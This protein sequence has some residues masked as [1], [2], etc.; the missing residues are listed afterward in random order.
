M[1]Y[2]AASNVLLAVNEKK[3]IAV[4]LYRPLRN[5]IASTFSERDAQDAEDDLQTVRKLR[6]D[7]EAGFS[8]SLELRRDL[9][10]SYLRALASI[11]PRFPISPDR[12]HV[13]SLTFTWFDAFR[14]N[15]KAALP[16][17]HLEKA[18]V[19]FNLGAVYS[20]IAVAADRTSASGLKQACNA[21]QSAAGA[22]SFLKD[23]VAAKAVAA[24]GTID[25]SVECTVMLEKLMLAQ[26]QECFFQKV[27]GDAKP[28]G[29]CSKVARQVGIYY[30]EAYAALNASLLNQHFDRT[31]MSH[32]QLKAAQ[33]YS[34][35]CYQYSLE[36]H[37]KEE[38]AEEIARLKIGISALTDAKKSAKGVA[39]PSLDAVKKLDTNMNNNLERAVKE[40]DRVYLMRIPAASSLSALPT[41]SLVKPTSL[42]EVLDASEEKF[43]SKLVPDSHTKAFSKYTDMAD[44]I[45]RIQL[46]KLQQGS[47]ITRVKLKELD[48]P[49]SILSLEGNIG[50]PFDLKEDVEVVQI[51]GGPSGLET[52]IQQLK[53]LRR[54]NQEL[55]A[56]SEE[57]LQKEADTDAQFRSQFGTRWTRPESNTLTKNIQ[58]KLHRFTVNLKQAADTDARVEREVRD[59]VEFLAILDH[60][61]IESTLPS[62]ARPIIS[63]DGNEDSIVG[64]LK[65]SLRQLENLGAQRAGLEDM[66]KE[67]KMK[68]NI[69]P[70]LMASTVSQED[71]F[72]KEISKYDQICEEISQNINAQEQLLLQIQS[73][74]DQFAA[75]FNLE[76]YKVLVV[77]AD[78][79]MGWGSSIALRRLSSA[80]CREI[81]SARDVARNKSYKQIAAAVAKYR[82]IK[83]NINEGMKFYVTLQD[84]LM[85]VKQQCSDFYMTRNTQCRETIE[86]VQRQIAGLNFASEGETSYNFPSRQSNSPSPQ[87]PEPQRTPLLSHP[88]PNPQTPMEQPEHGYFDRFAAQPNHQIASPSLAP[89][90]YNY[91][92]EQP[93]PGYS[94][95]Y[96]AYATPQPPPYY[97]SG[98]KYQHP[99]QVPSHEYRQPAYPGWHGPYHNAY[100]QQPGGPGSYPAPPYSVPAPYPPQQGSHHRP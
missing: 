46:E 51:S 30:E 71:L 42:G 44:N 75:M 34:E 90:L 49:D 43:F 55:L 16:S 4:D 45:I 94:H 40:N 31:W 47:E 98:S 97:A 36:L 62:L 15:K 83:E 88:T 6:L 25:L 1:S 13:S 96:P 91:I 89:P 33:F 21:L 86:Q 82:E 60:R 26:A 32:V 64:A 78:P 52:E 73:E 41:A 59:A 70:K 8:T 50:L 35:A 77:R 58:D 69:L 80:W 100:Q 39:S 24:G 19:L 7:L 3:T 28:P 76:D 74:N 56:Q 92:A 27:I 84:A 29:L 93:R 53:D 11:E 23:R 65:Q 14:P 38:I 9:L 20:Q 61:P 67:M 48:L 22:F 68:D 95:P 10:I 12:S 66:L 57:L 87:P 18:A 99:Q 37:E 54:I 2:S 81:I 72:K 79:S 63:L 85:N 17:I 5:Y